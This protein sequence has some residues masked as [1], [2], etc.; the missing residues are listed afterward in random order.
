[1]TTIALAGAVVALA[2]VCALALRWGIKQSDEASLAHGRRVAQQRM[3]DERVAEAVRQRDEYAAA[4]GVLAAQLRDARDRLATAERQR[5][6]STERER[7]HVEELGRKGD[8][9]A[10]AAA[11]NAVLSRPLPKL[12]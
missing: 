9:A 10:T 8:A 3:D 5:N 12:P 2:I 1:V 6:E 7:A 11:V 4:V